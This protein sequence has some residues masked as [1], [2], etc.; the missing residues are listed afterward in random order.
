[1]F[2]DLANFSSNTAQRNED[3][4]YTISFGCG[5]DAPNNLEIDNPSGFFNI[6]IRHY[7]PSEKVYEED[8]RLI[9]LMK[10]VSKE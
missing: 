8:Y 3:G 6:A 9:P 10:A 5:N 4:T 7:Q 1:M 2:N